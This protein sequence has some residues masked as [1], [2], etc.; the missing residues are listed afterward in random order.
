[1]TVFAIDFKKSTIRAFK[2]ERSARN[3]GN[4]L[5]LF[6][7]VD[8]LLENK[9][10]TN[11]GIISV[12]NNNADVAVKRFS[13]TRTGATRL[14]KLAQDIHVESTPFDEAPKKTPQVPP[15]EG[16]TPLGIAPKSAPFSRENMGMDVAKTDAKKPRGKFVGKCIKV[17]VDE[18]PRRAGGHGHKMMDWLLAENKKLGGGIIE[19]ADYVAAGGRPQ[20]LQWD[21]D[22]NWV[23]IV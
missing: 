19:Y 21:L 9:N 7:S 18:N 5:V 16:M 6:T 13:D 15:L 20:D 14:F 8:E 23:E 22:R 17:L 4:G 2:S 10:T 3:M 1:M 11:Q 12:Y